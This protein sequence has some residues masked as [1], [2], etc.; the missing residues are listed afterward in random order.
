[1]LVFLFVVFTSTTLDTYSA[2]VFYSSAQARCQT[3]ASKHSE[4][5]QSNTFYLK[6]THKW[7]KH[8]HKC[9]RHSAA[10]MLSVSCCSPIEPGHASVRPS[11]VLHTFY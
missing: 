2:A 4:V 3:T 5:T 8:T 1:M 9:P 6:S 11:L 7:P 10:T